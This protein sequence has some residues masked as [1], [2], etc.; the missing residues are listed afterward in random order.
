MFSIYPLYLCL[1]QFTAP[2]PST[3]PGAQGRSRAV[4]S[5]GRSHVFTRT[6]LLPGSCVLRAPSPPVELE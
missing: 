5:K 3:L 2:T 6:V 4:L 1:A